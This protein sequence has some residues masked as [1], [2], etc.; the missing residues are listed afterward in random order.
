MRNIKRVAVRILIVLVLCSGVKDVVPNVATAITAEAASIKL[1]KTKS[2]MYVGNTLQ[3]KLKGA[4]AKKVKWTSS[5]KSVAKVSSS[6]KVSALKKGTV[7]IKAK[8][9]NVTYKCKVT[10]KSA[11]I[12][13]KKLTLRVGQGYDLEVI[14]TVGKITWKSS[15]TKVAKVNSNGYLSP[16]AAGN[17]KITAKVG[18]ETYTCTLKVVPAF[19]ENDFVFDNPD[20]E[21]Y[22]NFIDYST[23]KGSSWYWFW[24]NP[25]GNYKCNRSINVGDTYNNFISAYGYCESVAVTSYDKYNKHFNN[26]AYPRTKVVLC[27]KDYFTQNEYYKTFYFDRN[28]TVVLIIWHR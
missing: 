11:K 24:D 18:K 12:S 1:S 19:S 15:N 3:L 20:D 22:T 8:Y 25:A 5:N 17:T 28:G 4:T 10:V 13:Q 16:K 9:K 21:G 2:T 26:S 14:N 7:T 23:N 6:G 27:Y